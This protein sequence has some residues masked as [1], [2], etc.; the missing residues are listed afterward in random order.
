MFTNFAGSAIQDLDFGGG[1][2]TGI[3]NQWI[4]HDALILPGNSGGPLVNMKGE[5]VGINTRGGSGAAFAA[6]N[7]WR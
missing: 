6:W 4:Q 7:S 1:Q 5:V 2:L 3:F